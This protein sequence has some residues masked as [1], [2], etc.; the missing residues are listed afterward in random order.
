MQLG[1]LLSKAGW[2]YSFLIKPAALHF[3]FT[4]QHVAGTQAMCDDFRQACA[5][6]RDASKSKKGWRGEPTIGDKAHMY[7][8]ASSSVNASSVQDVLLQYQ[9]ALLAP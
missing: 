4:L 3:C 5:D 2:T 7:G 1:E 9:D 8:M 6:V